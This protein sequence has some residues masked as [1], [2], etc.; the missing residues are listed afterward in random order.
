MRSS[1]PTSTRASTSSCVSGR[2]EGFCGGYDLVESSP[3]RTSAAA[4]GPR[5]RRAPCSTRASRPRNHDPSQAV[6]PDGRLRD[7]EPVQ[8]RLRQPAA[9]R[10]ADRGQDARL[11][12]GR[13]HRHRAA[14]PTRS[15][16]PPTPRS[17]TRRRGCGAFRPRAC[18]HTASATS[19]PS[20]CCS[21]GDMHHRRRGRRVGARRRGAPR[22]RTSTSAPRSCSSASPAMPVNQLIM[23]KLALNGA[24]RPGRRPPAGW[25]APSSTASPGTPARGTRSWR[26]AA[27]AGFRQAVRDRD[28]PFGDAGRTVHRG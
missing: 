9:R 27:E 10:Q 26:R 6:G 23:A 2:G 14:T 21:P 1:G 18:G 22:P 28:E 25:S 13:R 12:R 8:P 15:S 24:A 7:D 5:P 20:A 17:A 19:A 11:L 16:P 3:S 4:D